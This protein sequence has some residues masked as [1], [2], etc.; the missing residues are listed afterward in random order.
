MQTPE[1][2]NNLILMENDFRIVRFRDVGYAE[3]D[4]ADRQTILRRNGVPMV[5]C[6]IIPQPGANHIEIADEVRNRMD[7]MKRTCRMM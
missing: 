1:E 7:Q 5:S 4:A 2:F 6:V 3:L